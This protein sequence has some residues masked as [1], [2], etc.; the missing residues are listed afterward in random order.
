MS[1]DR[2]DGRQIVVA[3]RPDM[4]RRRRLQVLDGA[5]EWALRH[6]MIMEGA[7][8]LRQGLRFCLG[9]WGFW[10]LGPQPRQ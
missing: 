1:V 5:D 6:P 3:G 4:Q 7:T 2:G 9:D 8:Q 10:G